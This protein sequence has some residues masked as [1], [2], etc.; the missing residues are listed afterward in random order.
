M[1]TAYLDEHDSTNLVDSGDRLGNGAVFKRLGY[2]IE[3]LDLDEPK[4]LRACR[5]RV[6]SG[7]SVL[8]PNGPPGGR[9]VMRWNIRA[10]VSVRWEGAS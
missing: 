9:R 7:I 4:V 6:S 2:L 3:A 8:D 10:N 5:A 1:L